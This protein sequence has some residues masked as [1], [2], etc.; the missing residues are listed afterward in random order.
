MRR[1]EFS[2]G[3]ANKFWQIDLEASELR[4]AW[5]KIGTTGQSQNKSFA[6]SAAAQAELDKLVL[7]KTKKGYV[8]VTAGAALAV[9]A[10][11]TTPAVNAEPPARAVPAATKSKKAADP[12]PADDS[13]AAAAVNAGTDSVTPQ[14]TSA[15]APVLV[16]RVIP[17]APESPA[18]SVPLPT[19]AECLAALA[20][21]FSEPLWRTTDTHIIYLRA[22]LARNQTSTYRSFAERILLSYAVGKAPE[23]LDVAGDAALLQVGAMELV[24]PY[25]LSRGG[26]G[27]VIEVL[28]HTACIYYV[29]SGGQGGSQGY[30]EALQPKIESG[31][32][33]QG[34][35]EYLRKLLPSLPADVVAEGHA[36]AAKFRSEPLPVRLAMAFL[37]ADPQWLAEDTT[38]LLALKKNEYHYS[39][40][41]AVFH[42]LRDPGLVTRL[43]ARHPK[44]VPLDEL[45]NAL[46]LL[47]APAAI[48]ALVN[49]PNSSYIIERVGRIETLAVAKAM[50]EGLATKHGAEPA[51]AYFQ[52][53]PELAFL[54]MAPVVARGEK[55]APYVKPV[56]DALVRAHPELPTKFDAYLD[57]KSR[58][59][60][61]VAAAATAVPEATAT[62]LPK[63]LATPL[64][65]PKKAAAPTPLTVDVPALPK[66]LLRDKSR[67]LP[68]SAVTV[69]LSILQRSTLTAPHAALA[70]VKATLDTVSLSAFV[71]ALLEQWLASGGSSKD[72]W[73]FTA[74]GLLGDDE[75]ARRLTPLIRVW[76]GES[77]HGRAALGLDVLAEIGTDLSLMYLHG[78]SEKVKYKALQEKART[79]IN[80]IAA[81]RGL[82]AEELADRLVPDLGLDG[83][84]SLTLDFGGRSFRVGFDEALEPVVRDASGKTLTELPKPNK[85]DDTSQAAAA[86]ERWKTLK[87]DARAVASNQLIRLELAMCAQ[88]RWKCDGYKDFIVRHPLL[89][90]LARRLLWGVYEGEKLQQTFRVAEDGTFASVED[91]SLTLAPDALIGLVHRLDLPDAILGK[92]GGVFADYKILQPFDQLG[93]QVFFPTAAEK[94]ENVLK[95][96]G[97]AAVKTG[98][99]LGLELLGW[100]KGEPQDAGWVY[101]MYKPLPRGVRACF[102]MGG[103]ICMGGYDMTPPTQ[104]VDGMYLES[105]AAQDPTFAELSPVVFSELVREFAALYE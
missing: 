61:S 75:A 18:A 21:H 3:S 92:W 48:S 31:I 81:A 76:P 85:S 95:R 55:I 99:I 19:Q 88:R 64:P 63:V 69:L 6:S 39:V 57:G 32:M 72:N 86:T 82:S 101:D 100:R 90:H 62:E 105:G 93:R 65:P 52:R 17:A 51:K 73:A 4:I 74:V 47:A 104:D 11:S 12:I 49:D 10:K 56:L 46:G 35:A 5:G 60:F 14:A 25:L 80:A 33:L 36:V 1:F 30:F 43:A 53:R 70:E 2:E 29:R 67:S 22:G 54:A 83:D 34:F 84:G 77:Q 103:G 44:D 27:Y 42:Y 102:G 23:K 89:G 28:V 7:E 20:K 78:I 68:E 91:E 45:I 71:W 26:L 98:K 94:K 8:E 15:S 59:L 16:E 13:Q 97:K 38:Q 9:A 87:K 41:P 58:A 50:V 79:K 24:I 40:A 66:V 96:F 37:F